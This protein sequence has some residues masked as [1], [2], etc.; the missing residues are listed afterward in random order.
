MDYKDLNDYEVVY[1]V[2]E[3]DDDAREL[4]MMIWYKRD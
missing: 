1:M 4:N 2:K 3:N